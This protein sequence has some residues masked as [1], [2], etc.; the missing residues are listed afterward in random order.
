MAEAGSIALT[1][2]NAG[3]VLSLKT[4]MAFTSAAKGHDAICILADLSAFFSASVLNKFPLL[5][6]NRN[7]EN[8][9]AGHRLWSDGP[10]SIGKG[11]FL[12]GRDSTP[13]GHMLPQP[14]LFLVSSP[15]VQPNVW[16][17]WVQSRWCRGAPW[18]SSWWQPPSALYLASR[19]S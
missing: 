6:S 18:D 1:Q 16:H 12:A 3:Q 15:L 2:L 17:C 7:A 5:K 10:V 19:G 13:L 4:D 8:L 11:P 14:Q 9:T